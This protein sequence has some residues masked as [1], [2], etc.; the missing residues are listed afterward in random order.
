MKHEEAD[1]LQEEIWRRIH[2]KGMPINI[3]DG[4]NDDIAD[5]FDNLRD[6]IIEK[7]YDEPLGTV[8]IAGY[9]GCPKCMGIVGISSY[10]C[11]RCGVYIR[12]AKT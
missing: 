5:W 7:Y 1:K 2:K 4:S 10:Y 12:E 8:R 6:S 3:R 9:D 11:K